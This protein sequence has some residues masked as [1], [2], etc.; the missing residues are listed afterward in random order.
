MKQVKK[1]NI[2]NNSYSSFIHNKTETSN[3][4]NKK[5]RMISKDK[6]HLNTINNFHSNNFHHV[7]ALNK[8]HVNY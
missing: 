1:R 3:L 4:T 8:I 2:R 6:E 7:Q 5:I